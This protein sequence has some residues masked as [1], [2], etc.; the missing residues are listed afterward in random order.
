MLLWIFTV[1]DFF[2]QEK[3][4]GIQQKIHDMIMQAMNMRK[5]QQNEDNNS[6]DEK[7]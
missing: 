1:P 6:E 3:I 2:N 4:S 5:N 7:E